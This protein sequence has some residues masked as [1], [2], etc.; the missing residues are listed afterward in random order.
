VN[1]TVQGCEKPLRS[2][3]LCAMHRSRMARTGNLDGTA[4]DVEGFGALLD[5][6]LDGKGLTTPAERA[7]YDLSS[8][9]AGVPA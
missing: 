9:L 1:C 6:I 3:G 2:K 8:E 4:P 7:F 5:W